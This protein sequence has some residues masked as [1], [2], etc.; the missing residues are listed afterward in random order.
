MRHTLNSKLLQGSVRVALVGCGG[1]GSQVLTGL[2]RLHTAMIALGH[3]GGLAVTA[4]DPD[5]VSKSNVGRQLFSPADVGN[6]KA[7]LLIHRLNAFFGLA[8]KAK[9][10]KF[11]ADNFGYNDKPHIIVSCVDTKQARREIA[12][13][14]DFNPVPYWLDYGNEQVSGQVI[15]GQ[16]AY[17]HDQ[18]NKADR[19]LDLPCV[20]DL[21]PSILDEGEPEDDTPSCSL[22]ESLEKQDLFINQQ[23]ATSGLQLLWLLFRN[24]G[25]NNHGAFINLASGMVTPL[26]I[27]PEVWARFKPKKVRVR[28]P[29]KTVAGEA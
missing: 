10:S 20:T 21:F 12:K 9:P 29:K 3:P 6:N 1:T 13:F 25:L 2:A 17:R 27:D 23:V 11:E 18:R 26:P 24:G 15:L 14:C 28:K 19:K 7:V 5:V 16:P 22:A 8:W 4:Y